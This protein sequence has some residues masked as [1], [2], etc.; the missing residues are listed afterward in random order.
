M[1]TDGRYDSPSFCFELQHELRCTPPVTCRRSFSAERFHK[2]IAVMRAEET[3]IKK[4]LLSLS[5]HVCVVSTG[6]RYTLTPARR[7]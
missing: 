4:V 1:A 5:H 6:I 2:V 7:S 3:A